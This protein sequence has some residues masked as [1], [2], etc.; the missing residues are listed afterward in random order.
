MFNVRHH[1]SIV[2]NIDITCNVHNHHTNH[3]IIKITPHC[4]YSNVK[5]LKHFWEIYINGYF[6]ECPKCNNFNINQCWPVMKIK[7]IWTF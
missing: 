2:L 1:D 3:V 6:H 5:C 7:L 4:A